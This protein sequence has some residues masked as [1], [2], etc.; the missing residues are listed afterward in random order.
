MQ[1]VKLY[2]DTTVASKANDR[3]E[4]IKREGHWKTWE[5]NVWDWPEAPLEFRE[6]SRKG[7]KNAKNEFWLS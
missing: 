3:L 5:L 7:A 1:V 6:F 2:P 4:R